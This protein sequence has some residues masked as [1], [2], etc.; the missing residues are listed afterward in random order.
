MVLGGKVHAGWEADHAE[1]EGGPN[2]TPGSAP[3]PEEANLQGP[4]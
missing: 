1:E 2:R 3:F 4:F